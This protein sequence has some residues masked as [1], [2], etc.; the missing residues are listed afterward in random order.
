MEILKEEII[1][2]LS[3]LKIEDEQ[4]KQKIEEI[5]KGI[6]IIYQENKTLH[7]KINESEKFMP[8]LEENFE[9]VKNPKDLKYKEILT[10]NHSSA[11]YVLAYIGLDNIEYLI[12]NNRYN[13][14]LD[15][16]VIKTKQIITSLSGHKAGVPVIKYFLKNNKEEYLLS[17]DE[18]RLVII[19]DIQKNYDKK[20]ELQMN[21]SGYIYESIILFNISSKDY[22][23]VSSTLNEFTKVYE[24]NQTLPFIKDVYL[25]NEN[26]TQYIIY[27]K[28]NDKN[29]LIELCHNK[30]TIN[31]IF[32]NELYGTLIAKPCGYIY[33]GY[34]YNNNQNLVV[35]DYNYHYI[36]IWD[37]IKK[38]LHKEIIIDAISGLE[39]ISWNNTYGILACEPNSFLVFDI[40][41]GIKVK[42]IRV[43]NKDTRLCGVKKIKLSNIGECL[44]CSDY[45][46]TIYLYIP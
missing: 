36:R 38:E 14:N 24:F 29:Y 39:I 34:L 1:E 9:I 12:F 13:F 40:E 21:Y 16:M 44:I 42:T 19:W 6:E 4:E 5:K 32:E 33:S 3:S 41:N 26:E 28:Y 31:N 10:N 25:T 11:G 23:I 45:D 7:S 22:L 15:V 20:Y 17:A 18:N 43:N 8:K 30:I 27:W 37:L 2:K 35:S 46:N